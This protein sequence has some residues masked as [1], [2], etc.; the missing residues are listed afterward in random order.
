M[1]G[2]F[3]GDLVATA[4]VS[5]TAVVLSGLLIGCQSWLSTSLRCPYETSHGRAHGSWLVYW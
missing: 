3:R 2:P 4:S 1:S 5:L